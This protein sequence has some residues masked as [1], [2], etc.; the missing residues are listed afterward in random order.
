MIS[1]RLSPLA[2]KWLDVEYLEAYVRLTVLGDWISTSLYN[3]RGLI[4]G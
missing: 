2:Y 1:R 4:D 3:Y